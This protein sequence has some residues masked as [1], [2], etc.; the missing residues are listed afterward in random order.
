M[1]APSSQVRTP[2]RAKQSLSGVLTSQGV[3]IQG[4]QISATRKG[5]HTVFEDTAPNSLQRQDG[6]VFDLDAV[7]AAGGELSGSVQSAIALQLN[8]HAPVQQ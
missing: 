3:T 4:A 8:Q 6:D 5:M 2:L 1:A 7:Q